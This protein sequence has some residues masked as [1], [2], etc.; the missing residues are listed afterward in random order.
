MDSSEEKKGKLKV[1]VADDNGNH[2]NIMRLLLEKEGFI[3]AEAHSGEGAVHAFEEWAPDIVV[4]DSM[5]PQKCGMDCLLYIRNHPR[6]RE[7]KVVMCSA[8]T[9]IDYVLACLEAGADGFIFKPFDAERFQRRIRH[10]VSGGQDDGPSAN[11]DAA[12]S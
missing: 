11:A 7:V 1:L 6:Q 8:K 2:R 3:V 10:I 4:L 12:S 5:L 9:D